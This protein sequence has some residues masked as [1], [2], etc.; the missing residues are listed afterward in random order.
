MA[1]QDFLPVFFQPSSY[2]FFL[3]SD[4]V[5]PHKGGLR[6]NHQIKSWFSTAFGAQIGPWHSLQMMPL[7]P[8][9]VK[10]S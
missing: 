5:V 10:E 7:G 2:V 8:W 6:W 1:W 3:F 4:R 9:E